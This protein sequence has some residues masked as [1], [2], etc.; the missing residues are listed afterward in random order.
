MLWHAWHRVA[1]MHQTRKRVKKGH[2]P[3]AFLHQFL[4]RDQL[5]GRDWQDSTV[6]ACT[7]AAQLLALILQLWKGRWQL[8]TQ[9]TDRASSGWLE[10][11]AIFL[12][13]SPSLTRCNA[14][15]IIWNGWNSSGRG[16]EGGSLEGMAVSWQGDELHDLIGVFH[17]QYLWLPDYW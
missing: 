3:A 7:K 8:R 5:T 16:L 2:F 1:M 13:W 10:S 15:C 4:E 17:L 14:I 11:E 6:T 9:I 12:L